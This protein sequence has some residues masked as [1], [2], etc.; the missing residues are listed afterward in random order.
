[1]REEMQRQSLK[2]KSVR[3]MFQDE[4]RFGRINKPRRCWAPKGTRPDIH[5]QVVREYTYAYVAASPH[6]GVMDSLILPEVNAYAMSI[7]LAEVAKRHSDE[8][9][10]MVM[11]QA[12]WHKAKDLTIPENIRLI[13]QP[14]YS[15]QCNPIE[16]I[17]DEIRE[18]WFPNLVFKSMQAVEDTLAEALIAL[19]NDHEK[20]QSITGHKWIISISM[21][22][23]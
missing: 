10:L 7:F 13:W 5:V 21:N 19:E 17:W 20:I 18:K 4:G 9:I 3:L 22:A 6:D 16:N 1:M 11:D 15:P 23:T 8:F 2:N 14:P 12:G